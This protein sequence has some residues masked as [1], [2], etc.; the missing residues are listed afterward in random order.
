MPRFVILLSADAL[1]HASVFWCG[2]AIWQG[3]AQRA[4]PVSRYH[5]TS[6][7][8][9]HLPALRPGLPKRLFL[10]GIDHEQIDNSYNQPITFK[11]VD[12]EV[13]YL[14]QAY[15]LDVIIPHFYF[16][17]TTAYAIL[18]HHGVEPRKKDYIDNEWRGV[19]TEIFFLN[20]WAD[21]AQTECLIV[22]FEFLFG[23]IF[24]FLP[25]LIKAQ[26]QLVDLLFQGVD[27]FPVRGFGFDLVTFH[28]R[29]SWCLG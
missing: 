11:L 1:I 4:W 22:L 2:N 16:H 23:Q 20:I 8:K 12:K 19:D 5:N 13:V 15:L 26:L 9:L 21:Q 18:R 17:V 14:S 28:N 29:E 24:V 10:Q 3:L 25:K 6:I 27:P 7:S